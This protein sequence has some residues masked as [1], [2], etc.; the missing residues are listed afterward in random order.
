MA[1][2]SLMLRRELC[3]ANCEGLLRSDGLALPRPLAILGSGAAAG[4][5][6]TDLGAD[7]A[8]DRQRSNVPDS[9]ARCVHAEVSYSVAFP[10]GRACQRER[11]GQSGHQIVA[12]AGSV[13]CLSEVTVTEAQGKIRRVLSM[14]G[15][16]RVPAKKC[17]AL[18]TLPMDSGHQGARTPTCTEPSSSPANVATVIGKAVKF[19]RA[20]G[21][22]A[23]GA[24]DSSRGR[25]SGCFPRPAELDGGSLRRPPTAQSPSTTTLNDAVARD[26][27]GTLSRL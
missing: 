18:S 23:F 13:P 2:T 3:W 24:M 26:P 22:F 1:A 5:A 6:R 7:L 16:V 20:S 11:R 9:R 17:Q 15:Q 12:D 10:V 8:L 25:A 4:C 19:A 14:C 27:D 21:G